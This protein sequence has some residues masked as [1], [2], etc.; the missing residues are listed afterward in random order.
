MS[1]ILWPKVHTNNDGGKILREFTK[2][3]IKHVLDIALNW[4]NS[5]FIPVPE[6][7]CPSKSI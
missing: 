1:L 4:D 5:Q 2:L 6:F 3:L 7:L